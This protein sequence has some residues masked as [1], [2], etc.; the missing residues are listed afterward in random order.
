MSDFIM[1]DLARTSGVGPYHAHCS[2][3]YR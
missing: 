3:A 1:F 2:Y